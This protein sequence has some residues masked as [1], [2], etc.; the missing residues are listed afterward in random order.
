MRRTASE[1]CINLSERRGEILGFRQGGFKIQA[2]KI[3]ILSKL[4]FK[5]CAV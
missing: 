5:P 3:R 2:R 1:R 4:D